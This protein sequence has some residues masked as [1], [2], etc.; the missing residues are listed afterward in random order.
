MV[1][2]CCELVEEREIN[3]PATV[4]NIRAAQSEKLL[5]LHDSSSAPQFK[6]NMEMDGKPTAAADG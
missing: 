3:G 1:V 4:G 5:K 2:C 6:E